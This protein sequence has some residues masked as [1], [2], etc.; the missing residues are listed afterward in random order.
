MFIR[1]FA[2]LSLLVVGLS[3]CQKPIEMTSDLNA[4]QY[5][6]QSIYVAPANAEL[7]NEPEYWSMKKLITPKLQQK[8]AGR[9]RAPSVGLKINV[10]DVNTSINVARAMLIGDS[11]RLW[12]DIQ[13]YD[14][15][16]KRQLGKT[17]VIVN[18]GNIG[19]AA[20][21]IAHGTVEAVT[22]QEVMLADQFVAAVIDKLYPKK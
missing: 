15:Q 19:G 8:L 11:Y 22:E 4:G 20:G 13:L 14:L 10:I 2:L 12:A 21:L 1:R 18:G 5:Q 17:Q 6:I 16:T 3:A 7:A 9:G